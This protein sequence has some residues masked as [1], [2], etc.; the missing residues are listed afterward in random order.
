M[1]TSKDIHPIVMKVLDELSERYFIHKRPTINSVQ[2]PFV[3]PTRSTCADAR[4]RPVTASGRSL[5]ATDTTNIGASSIAR[6]TFRMPCILSSSRKG[7]EH[8][9]DVM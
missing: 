1:T 5:H 9:Y 8:T 7:N 4:S 6:E 3:S 2:Y